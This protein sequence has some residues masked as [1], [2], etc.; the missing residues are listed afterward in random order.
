LH[1]CEIGVCSNVCLR[2]D[3]SC[4]G[5]NSAPPASAG[6][7]VWYQ[8]LGD[9]PNATNPL[10]GFHARACMIGDHDCTASMLGKDVSGASGLVTVP[11]EKNVHT[12]LVSNYF[13]LTGP[14]S[15]YPPYLMFPPQWILSHSDWHPLPLVSASLIRVVSGEPP[16][17]T[18]GVVF[19]MH[20][21]NPRFNGRVLSELAGIAVNVVTPADSLAQTFYGNLSMTSMTDDSGIGFIKNVEPGQIELEARRV[22]QGDLIETRKITVRA[23]AV[24][25]VILGPVP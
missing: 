23:G 24:T 14:D 20:D 4:L 2:A 12:G 25:H 18:G 15:T 22:P 11:L 9:F 10:P 13:E 5:E 21:C 6:P 3:W 17:G 7:L 16:P 1:A 19:Q 8:T